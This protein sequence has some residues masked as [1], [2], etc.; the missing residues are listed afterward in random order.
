MKQLKVIV[1]DPASLSIA[2]TGGYVTANF[3]SP[4]EIKKGSLLCLD[5]F[6]ATSKN[7]S[8]NFGIV[9][10]TFVMVVNAVATGLD[11]AVSIPFATY[12]SIAAYMAVINQNVNAT[13]ISAYR[14]LPAGVFY[15]VNNWVNTQSQLSMGVELTTTGEGGVF[16]KWTSTIY[17]LSALSTTPSLDWVPSANL[18]TNVDGLHYSTNGLSATLTAGQACMV[19]GGIATQ[20]IIRASSAGNVDWVWGFSSSNGAKLGGKI[21]QISGSP[22]L[23][24]LNDAGVVTEIL[25]S[26]TLFPNAYT[27]STGSPRFSLLQKDGK[28]GFA[29]CDDVTNN[30]ADVDLYCIDDQ[31][32]GKMGTWN[33]AETFT[34][35]AS[36][37]G[38]ATPFGTLTYTPLT[39][40]A[41][42]YPVP[43]NT[44]TLINLSSASQLAVTLGF[45]ASNYIFSPAVGSPVAIIQSPA[46]F[47]VN[48]LRSAFELAIEILD[49]P[50]KT[51]F[52]QTGANA[53]SY[54]RQNVIC[55][56]TPNPSNETEGLYSFANAAHQWLE[57]DNVS[58]Q[59]IQSLSFRIF[60]S[61]TGQ[62]FVS[63]SMGFNL[64]I[65]NREEVNTF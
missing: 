16:S 35:S 43:S 15:D 3:V 53:R 44:A 26:Q 49:I 27:A 42:G 14:E 10:Q 33:Y 57:I 20:G 28:F 36:V 18:G 17:G 52:A 12:P 24:V 32:A 30:N 50:L 8:Q 29:Y 39:G 40:G 11:V 4:V 65:K 63:N 6:N 45:Q 22:N 62:S 38:G 51:Y 31:Y 7:I 64:L 46:P 21:A 19:G 61:Y 34:A 5:K 60:N 54:G 59:I 56:F 23:F 9:A 37:L 13:A 2:E 1:N 48:Q 41:Q 55:Y 47:N 58:D 25:N